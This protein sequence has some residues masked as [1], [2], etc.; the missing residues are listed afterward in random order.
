MI[1]DLKEIESSALNLSKRD[2]VRLAEKL[3]QSI[4]GQ[5]NPDIEEA[6]INEVQKRKET[7]KSGEADLY[8]SAEVLKEAKNRIRE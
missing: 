4:H 6:W 5:L 7:L 3:L 2:K 1:T 8:S